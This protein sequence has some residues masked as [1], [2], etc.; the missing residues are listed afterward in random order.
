M[1]C[2]PIVLPS[3]WNFLLPLAL[4]SSLQL[5]IIHTI[6]I[7][8][9][10]IQHRWTLLLKFVLF[11]KF[12]ISGRDSY[13]PQWNRYL[14]F[15]PLV[16]AEWK[17]K[18]IRNELFSV[19]S[20]NELFNDTVC[21]FLFLTGISFPSLLLLVLQLIVVV[22]SNHWWCSPSKDINYSLKTRQK[23]EHGNISNPPLNS[24]LLLGSY[25]CLLSV[26]NCLWVRPYSSMLC[27]S[28]GC[29]FFF[30]SALENCCCYFWS[31]V[32]MD[33]PL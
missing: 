29:F 2:R 17:W 10:N 16:P 22:Q 30:K 1:C 20:D 18:E 9:C 13:L 33:L 31:V 15:P 26:L 19:C 14:W 11:R 7:V 5:T 8:S 4:I 6:I 12:E 24:Y 23:H 21:S 3:C 25:A 28:P 32:Y 27:C